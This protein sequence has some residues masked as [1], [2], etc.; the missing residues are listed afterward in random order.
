MLEY[1]D[2]RYH[3]AKAK[4]D[5]EKARRIQAGWEKVEPWIP[6]L[7]SGIDAFDNFEQGHYVKATLQAGLAATEGIGIGAVRKL[8]TSGVKVGLKQGAKLLP[9]SSSFKKPPN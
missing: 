9:L 1:L 8:V 5:E 2:P 3:I 7:G 4:G 6:V